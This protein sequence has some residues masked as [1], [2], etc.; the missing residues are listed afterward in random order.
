MSRFFIA[1]S[2]FR[3]VMPLIENFSSS[4]FLSLPSYFSPGRPNLYA[5]CSLFLTGIYDT[6]DKQIKAHSLE[7]A[8][9]MCPS[10]CCLSLST[11]F[12]PA[13]D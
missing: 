10:L 8:R 6:D 7:T 2:F 11:W 9:R 5:D 3:A 12:F 13:G 4:I 1:D